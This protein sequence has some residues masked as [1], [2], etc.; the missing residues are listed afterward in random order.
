M[1]GSLIFRFKWSVG[2]AII[3][4]LVALYFGFKISNAIDS[5]KYALTPPSLP[6]YQTLDIHYLN[7]QG[8]PQTSSE[9]FHHA[10]QGTATIPVPYEWLM[11]LE[12][13]KSNPWMLFFGEEALLTGEYMLRHGF[14]AQSATAYNPDALPI[15][16]AK[17]PSIYFAGINR[18]ATAAGFTCA[19]CHTGQMV[20]GETRYVIDGA[21]AST[22]LGLFTRSLGAA[23]GQTVLSSKV[24]ILNGR[25]DRFARR[26]LGSNDNIVTRNQLKE[27]L[28][29]TIAV[30]A[31]SSDVITVTEGFSRLDALNRIGNQVFSKDMS[32]PANYSPINAP[33]NYPHIWTTSWFNWVQYDG[34]IMQPLIRNAGEALGVSAFV[35][36]SGPDEQRFASSVN[37][38]SLVKMEKWL[39]GTQPQKNG[40]Q[41]NGL[42]APSWPVQF[43]AIDAALASEGEQLYQ[44]L[45]QGCHLPVVASEAFWQDQHWQPI[46]YIENATVTETAENYLTLHIIPLAEIGTDTAQADVLQTRTVDTTGLNLA[47]RVCTPVKEDNASKAQLRYVDLNDS[48]TANFGLALGAFVE[49]TNQQWFRQN[50]VSAA[51]QADMEGGRPN[52]LQVGQGYKARPLNGIWST[53]P[54]LHNGSVANIYDLLSAERPVFVL[55]GAQQFDATKLGIE[56][57]ALVRR[58]A[59]QY[60]ETEPALT[61]DYEEGY[62]ILDSRQPGNSHAGHW[63]DDKSSGKQGIVGPRL[64]ENQKLALLEYLKTL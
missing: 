4:V 15:G 43:P 38:A 1:A 49:R 16:I 11:A 14:I 57:P 29:D 26:V 28:A 7:N 34:S 56:Q 8:W 39:S 20:Y 19:A 46:R 17:T 2:T 12:A 50:Y 58:F 30:L 42:L 9:W 52:C 24:N 59:A 21:P 54:Y 31:Q 22:D 10:S 62:F 13:P 47:T 5:I 41:F 51:Q 33:V 25:F 40:D 61:P 18:K 27:E 23:L 53:A 35:D 3:V 63:F 60:A 36:S 32:R 37:Y 55:L 44:R 45:C 6:D 64:A 48:A